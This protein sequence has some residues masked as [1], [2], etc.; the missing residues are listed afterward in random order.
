MKIVIWGTGF[1]ASRF[2]F[3]FSHDVV[4]FFIDN[5]IGKKEFHGKK[6]LHPSEISNWNE[7]FIYVPDNYYEEISKQLCGKGLKEKVNFV[8]YTIKINLSIDRARKELR[9][10]INMLKDKSNNWKGSTLCILQHGRFKQYYADF[11][12]KL[13]KNGIRWNVI[14]MAYWM[15]ENQLSSFFESDTLIGPAFLDPDVLVDMRVL[16]HDLTGYNEHQLLK[17]KKLFECHEYLQQV[18][19]QIIQYFGGSPMVRDSAEISTAFIFAYFQ[20]MIKEIAPKRIICWESVSPSSNILTYICAKQGV[21]IIYT[22]PGIVP[23]TLSFDIGGEMGASLPAIYVEKFSKLPINANL[24]LKSVREVWD[25][26]YISKLNRKVQPKNNI[27][28]LIASQTNGNKA[29]IFLAGV[30]DALSHMIPYT[31][32]S[33]KLHSP[34]FDSSYAAMFYLAELC[35]KNGWNLVFKP[36]PLYLPTAA[37][38]KKLPTN[39]ILVENG[40]V[41]EIIDFADVTITILSATSYNALIRYKPVVMLGYTQ[42]RGKGCTYEAFEKDKIEDAIKA[43]LENGFTQEQ[44][45][46]FL[47]HMAQCLK[48]YLYDDLQER[49]IRYGRP[50]PKSME[51]FYELER[52]LKSNVPRKD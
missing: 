32:Q 12:Q 20:T 18:A 22:H 15:E 28:K 11:L 50:V 2:Y 51:E 23:G 31:I 26:L 27:T 49:P 36:H 45:D 6:V 4:D 9:R 39:V 10:S 48:Y 37:Q 19:Q 29:T 46:A 42:L 38:R 52:L 7:L 1:N 30:H 35:K 17:F 8:K 21:P 47:L 13:L 3:G 40:D 25:F 16:N 43:A 24:H 44:Q 34:I 41:N 33:K 5:D 14:S